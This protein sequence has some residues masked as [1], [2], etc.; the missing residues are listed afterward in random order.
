[1]QTST[2]RRN[3]L[4]PIAL[5][6][7][8]DWF[9]I[10]EARRR[11][12]SGWSIRPRPPLWVRPIYAVRQSDAKLLRMN[13]QLTPADFAHLDAYLRSG[14]SLSMLDGYLAA[15]ASGP[16]FAMPDR[17]LQWM[18]GVAAS[19]NPLDSDIGVP[20]R[21]ISDLIVRL[22]QTVNDALN[23]QVYVSRTTD[24]QAWC[25]GYLAGVAADMT[26]WAPL[27]AVL[28]QLLTVIV[29]GAVNPRPN[30]ANSL[31][32]AARLIHAFWLSRRRH[33][34]SP[35]GFLGQLTA[36]SRTRVAMP[37]ERMR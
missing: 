18:W 16:N 26:S 9:R 3:G 4:L 13:T 21:T 32:D 33:E 15:V 31:V 34:S 10:V 35:D 30:G 11:L 2:N 22:Y 14:M 24:P 7:A 8:E 17:V 29:L 20:D 23:D 25:R 6:L 5:C 37:D 36:M 27:T 19:V 28:P 12:V 1:M